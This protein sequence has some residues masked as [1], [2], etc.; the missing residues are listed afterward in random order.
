MAFALSYSEHFA[1]MS[2]LLRTATKDYVEE[3][4]I[5]HPNELAAPF[6]LREG[7]RME[8]AEKYRTLKERELP[9]CSP[10]LF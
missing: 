4:E 6:V 10:L 8:T 2:E 1:K 7:W 9:R 3:F 5:P